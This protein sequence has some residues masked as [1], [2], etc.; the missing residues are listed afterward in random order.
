MRTFKALTSTGDGRLTKNKK[1]R[2]HIVMIKGI[3]R[4]CI[5]DSKNEPMTF[6]PSVFLEIK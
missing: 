6:D 3:R 2:G 4:V 1:Y 5:I